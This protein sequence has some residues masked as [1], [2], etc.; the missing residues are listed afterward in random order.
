MYTYSFHFNDD[1]YFLPVFTKLF[2]ILLYPA[3]FKLLKCFFA[4]LFT[5]CC[6]GIYSRL[7]FLTTFVYIY[8]EFQVYFS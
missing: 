6:K 1:I 2:F 5:E 4:D 3:C 7:F 8:F